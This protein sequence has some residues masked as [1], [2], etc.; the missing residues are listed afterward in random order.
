M[1]IQ[2]FSF[3][4]FEDC[5]DLLFY[6]I[7]NLYLSIIYI[8]NADTFPSSIENC[9]K[10]SFCTKTISRGLSP[11]SRRKAVWLNTPS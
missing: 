4:C 11:S 9:F 3:C 1:Y 8:Y 5:L 10:R 6:F 7:F 2:S